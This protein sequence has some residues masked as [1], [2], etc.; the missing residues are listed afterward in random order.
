MHGRI[1]S[2]LFIITD[3]RKAEGL[4]KLPA[5]CWVIFRATAPRVDGKSRQR[6]AT[7]GILMQQQ[8]ADM[9]F[10]RAGAMNQR[11]NRMV[12]VNTTECCLVILL[13]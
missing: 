13:E 6:D 9:G 7:S 10:A 8:L 4:L 3:T 5:V 2:C 11:S 12:H 1:G